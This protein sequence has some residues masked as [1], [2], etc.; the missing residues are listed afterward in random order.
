MVD[1]RNDA[2]SGV[3]WDSVLKKK[4]TQNHERSRALTLLQGRSF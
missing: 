2:A 1:F 4:Q 3:S